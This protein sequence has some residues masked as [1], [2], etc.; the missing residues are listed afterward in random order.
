MKELEKSVDELFFTC[1]KCGTAREAVEFDDVPQN[2]KDSVKKMMDAMNP[3]LQDND[4]IPAFIV[5][6]K[7]C[8]EYSTV[9]IGGGGE[10]M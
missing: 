10:W 5:F 1:E 2:S 4:D 3:I 9:I 6:C 8:N 7:K